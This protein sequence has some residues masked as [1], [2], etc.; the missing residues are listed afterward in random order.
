[1]KPAKS[2]FVL[3]WF[4]YKLKF[5]IPPILILWLFT[6]DEEFAIAWL[7]ILPIL[8]LSLGIVGVA[9]YP[10][11]TITVLDDRINGPTRWGTFWMRIDMRFDEI[12][13]EKTL[14]QQFGRKLGMT[15]IHSRS[16][17]KILTLG[18]DDEQLSRDGGEG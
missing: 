11:Y 16:G 12:D 18:L 5:L 13:R 2:R 1:M 6:R 7:I 10:Y 8:L 3:A 17:E 9:A 14:R 4:V 15:V